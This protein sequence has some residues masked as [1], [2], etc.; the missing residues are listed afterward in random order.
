MTKS[1]ILLAALSLLS[2]VPARSQGMGGAVSGGIPATASLSGLGA[3]ASGANSDITS[4]TALTSVKF[5]AAGVAFSSAPVFH[6]CAPVIVGT[7][8]SGTTFM[9]FTPDSPITL[10]RVSGTVEVA[11]IGG[12]GDTVKCNN[13]AGTGVSVTLSA[14]AAAGATATTTGSGAIAAQSAVSCHI[15]SAATTRP[16]ATFCVEYV[17]Q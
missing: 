12:A 3:A 9:T 7:L 2:V 1:L 11:G 6:A 14:A 5:G 16:I 13:S 17:L 4:L 10:I 15:D 8:A